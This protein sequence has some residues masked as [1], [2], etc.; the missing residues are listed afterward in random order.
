LP[1]DDPKQRKPDISKA[2]DVL[3]WKPKTAL[4]EGLGKTIRYFEM[5]LSGAKPELAAPRVN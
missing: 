3:G 1:P 2:E 4:R 5:L